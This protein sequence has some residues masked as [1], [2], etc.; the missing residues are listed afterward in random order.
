MTV[1]FPEKKI[2]YVDMDGVVADFEKAIRVHISNWDSLNDDEKGSLT[3]SL[4]TWSQL[5]EPSKLLSN[6]LCL[7]KLIFF[8]QLCGMCQ[9]VI[10]KNV[11]GFRIILAMLFGKN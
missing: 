1:Y 3:D 8:L 2:L 11:S 4:K 5:K 10:L 7:T 9:T 6:L